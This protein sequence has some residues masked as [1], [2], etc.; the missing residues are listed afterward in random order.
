MQTKRIIQIMSVGLLT[1]T[2][3]FPVSTVEAAIQSSAQGTT[4]KE[5]VKAKVATDRIAAI[6]ARSDKQIE[7]RISALNDVNTKVQALKHVSSSEKA[8]IASIVQTNISGLT[9][10]KAKIDADTDLA[11]LQADEKS[12]LGSYRIY[13]LVIPQ[14]MILVSADRVVTIA[15]MLTTVSSKLALRITEAQ[16]AGKDVT[17][18]NTTLAD[19]NAKIALAKT[20]AA[21]AQ[22]SVSGLTPDQGDKAR[23][24]ANHK[25][26]VDARTHI[27]AATEA[28][29]A[30]RKDIDIITKGLKAFHLKA[31]STPVTTQ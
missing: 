17:S 9:A 14:G 31:T 24:E 4:V 6:I 2:A 8:S 10:L 13:A 7:E 27:K 28:I 30:A 15:D 25:A 19:L 3:V 11:T 20:E 16:T 12:I 26:L 18:L 1:F 29:K 22:S 21:T 5:T 23:A